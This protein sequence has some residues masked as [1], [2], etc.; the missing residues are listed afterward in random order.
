MEGS[1]YV[2]VY[3]FIYLF[4][5][6]CLLLSLS[7]GWYVCCDMHVSLCFNLSVQRVPKSF[8]S[9]FVSFCLLVFPFFLFSFVKAL[10]CLLLVFNLGMTVGSYSRALG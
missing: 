10:H 1:K 7:F 8:L 5:P 6:P 2:L 3:L 4:L 9:C